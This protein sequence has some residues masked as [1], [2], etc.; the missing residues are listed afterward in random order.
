MY[1]AVMS[2]ITQWMIDA[3]ISEG[4]VVIKV[5]VW[6]VQS[7]QKV[8]SYYWCTLW[9]YFTQFAWLQVIQCSTVVVIEKLSGKQLDVD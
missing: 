1:V 8:L 4:W 6:I 7:K 5:V 9:I 3:W 2:M